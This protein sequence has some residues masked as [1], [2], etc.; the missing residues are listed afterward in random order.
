MTS[1]S[2]P[3]DSP[4]YRQK[5]SERPACFSDEGIVLSYI[6][7][8]ATTELYHYVNKNKMDDKLMERLIGYSVNM[9]KPKAFAVLCN[10]DKRLVPTDVMQRVFHTINCDVQDNEKKS[11]EMT[12]MADNAYEIAGFLS[13]LGALDAGDIA[14]AM[15]IYKEYDLEPLLTALVNKFMSLGVDK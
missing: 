6:K 2:L 1:Y 8:E 3:T 7:R 12:K 15:E 13:G 14:E 11:V 4:N 9:V 5:D 10:N